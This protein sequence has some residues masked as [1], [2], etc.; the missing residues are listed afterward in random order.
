MFW[1]FVSKADIN[2]DVDM[3]RERTVKEDLR[4]VEKTVVV[5][6]ATQRRM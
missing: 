2:V 3:N 6:A 4:G 1:Y 5:R